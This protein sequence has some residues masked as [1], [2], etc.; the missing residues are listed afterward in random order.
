MNRLRRYKSVQLEAGIKHDLHRAIGLS[1]SAH[2]YGGKGVSDAGT[3]RL[4][5]DDYRLER[6]RN[7]GMAG[8]IGVDAN[9]GNAR[10]DEEGLAGF[11]HDLAGDE[12]GYRDGHDASAL[13]IYLVIADGENALDLMGAEDNGDRFGAHK[14]VKEDHQRACSG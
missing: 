5:R 2:N 8:V 1:G 4:T 11:N 14:I 9:A 6:Y 7:P 10:Q 12:V 13:Q 3:K